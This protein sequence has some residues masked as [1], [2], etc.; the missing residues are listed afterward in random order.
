MKITRTNH[1]D[2]HWIF[3]IEDGSKLAFGKY[4]SEIR[5]GEAYEE[6]IKTEEECIALLEA[7][8]L[9]RNNNQ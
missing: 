4:F 7:T 6:G 3:Y 5:D 2:T 9:E 8:L 1:N